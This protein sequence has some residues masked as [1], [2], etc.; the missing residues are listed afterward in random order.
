[1]HACVHTPLATHLYTCTNAYTYLH[2]CMHVCLQI[3]T[4]TYP[5]AC[6]THTHRCTYTYTYTYAY[7]HPY[8][9]IHTFIHPSIQTSIHT[10]K[11]VY[12]LGGRAPLAERPR[13]GG[14]RR[15][16]RAGLPLR[17]Q[18]RR[19]PAL[20]RQLPRDPC[21]ESAGGGGCGRGVAWRSPVV[22]ENHCFRQPSTEQGIWNIIHASPY[23]YRSIQQATDAHV[24]AP[25]M[26]IMSMPSPSTLT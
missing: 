15:A 26:C 2:T 8:T 21:E 1:M 6:T 10:T 20:R 11:H 12:C 18:Q 3:Y 24:G 22:F 4:H 25:Y 7:T 5:Q 9:A 19:A 16:D 14:A 23:T 13:R 17:R